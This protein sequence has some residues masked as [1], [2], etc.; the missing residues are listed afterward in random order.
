MRK[1]IKLTKGFT[2][3]ELMVSVS[4]F[5][6][7]MISVLGTLLAIVEAN[8][9]A[10]SLKLAM[11]NLNFAIE[12]MA[13]DIRSGDTF[14][15]LNTGSSETTT[16][17]DCSSGRGKLVFTA[18][19]GKRIK[20]YM[21]GGQLKTAVA[22]DSVNFPNTFPIIETF[23]SNLVVIENLTF[24]VNGAQINDSIQPTVTISVQGYAG[25]KPTLLSRF[26]IQ[27]TVTKRGLDVP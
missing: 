21:L 11:N 15:C 10:Q 17:T 23:S 13:R 12:K 4:V 22:P 14:T 2:L 5:T 16:K 20:Y 7:V 19:T 25:N 9:K 18:R 6:I 1:K 8:R 27:T 26:S 24:F 3:V